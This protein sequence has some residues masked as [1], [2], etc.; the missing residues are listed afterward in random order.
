VVERGGGVRFVALELSAIL[1]VVSLQIPQQSPTR[2]Q[3]GH[4]SMAGV[5]KLQG[6]PWLGCGGRCCAARC[7]PGHRQ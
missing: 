3:S 1:S 7:R 2:N 5:R 6:H 4:R